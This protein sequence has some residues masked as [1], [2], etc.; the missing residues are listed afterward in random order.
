M[1]SNIRLQVLLVLTVLILS[2]GLSKNREIIL[3]KISV[4]MYQDLQCEQFTKFVNAVCN[5]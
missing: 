4:F 2:R 1:L 5:H 3:L